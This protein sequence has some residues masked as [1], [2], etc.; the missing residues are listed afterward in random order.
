MMSSNAVA[1]A[2]VAA[3]LAYIHACEDEYDIKE[4]LLQAVWNAA[5]V[6]APKKP[7]MRKRFVNITLNLLENDHG[8]TLPRRS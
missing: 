7:D 4:T 3:A 2:A 1:P 5:R 6:V 8:I